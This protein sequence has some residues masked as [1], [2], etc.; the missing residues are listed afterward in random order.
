MYR[1]IVGKLNFLTNT[2]SNIVFSVQT[3]SQ[4]M[5]TPRTAHLTYVHHV[6]QY[7]FGTQ[8][9]RILIQALHELKLQVFSDSD[10]AFCHITRRSI[11]S[12]VVML[13]NFPLSW[14]SKK[15]GTVSKSSS[16]AKY[17]A[18]SQATAEITWLVRLLEKLGLHSLKPVSLYFDNQSAL[19]IAKNPSFHK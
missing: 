6:L 9:Q 8:G 1:T 19:H 4:F 3:L 11:T 18:M 14:K 7:L 12:Y 5:Q 16:K 15:Q 2:R 13:G 17:R 10:K